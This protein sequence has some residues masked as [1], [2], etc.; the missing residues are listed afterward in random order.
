[1]IDG[2]TIDVNGGTRVRLI[3]IDTPERGQ[4]GYNAATAARAGLVAGRRVALIGGARD[5]TD[6]YG[7]LLRYVEVDNIDVN[8]AMINMGHAIARYDGLD[9]YGRHPRQD[10]YRAADA[11]SPTAGGGA[12][13]QPP[14][15]T[16]P[17]VVPII[18]GGGGGGGNDVYYANCDAARRA[19]VTPL[20]LGQPGYRPAL[21]RDKD[22][23]A[24]E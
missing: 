21:D 5:D 3:G 8:L 9:G 22:G 7:R 23:V 14:T 11:A 6:R 13:D 10:E 24:C 19:G 15:T 2:D 18:P 1:V 16:S 12:C 20:Y 17:S 4:C